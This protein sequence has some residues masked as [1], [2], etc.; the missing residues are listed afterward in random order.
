MDGTILIEQDDIVRETK[1]FYE[2]LYKQEDHISDVDLEEIN[3][4]YEEDL[5]IN[6]WTMQRHGRHYY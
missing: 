3:Q 4:Q 5:K 2:N 6:G 1:V